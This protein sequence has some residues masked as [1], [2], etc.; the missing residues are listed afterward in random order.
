MKPSSKIRNAYN[1]WAEIYDSNQNATRDLN[2]RVL[3]QES[4]S[5]AGKQ[6]LEIGCGTG[7]NTEYLSTGAKQVTGMDFSEEMLAHAK[8]RVTQRNVQFISGDITHLWPFE[9]DSFDFIT[10]NLVLE[11]V[12]NVAFIFREACRILRSGGHLYVSELHPYR[13]LQKSQ[14]KYISPETGQE[15]LVDAYYHSVPEY[16]NAGLN[17]GFILRRANEHQNESDETPRLF[18]LFFEKDESQI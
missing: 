11:H 13:Q 10:A 16:I 2:A 1:E 7:I 4:F 18:A 12:E 15:V 6:V 17:S 5:L 9:E 8:K 3:R 14:A